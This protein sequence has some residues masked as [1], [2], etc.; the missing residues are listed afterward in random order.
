MFED[1]PE[2]KYHPWIVRYCEVMN[3]HYEGDGYVWDEEIVLRQVKTALHD[4]REIMEITWGRM[5]SV[6]GGVMSFSTVYGH[7]WDWDE[8]TR[9]LRKKFEEMAYPKVLDKSLEDYL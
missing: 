1:V 7:G 6:L 5:S 2:V 9:A 8:E 4:H 3:L